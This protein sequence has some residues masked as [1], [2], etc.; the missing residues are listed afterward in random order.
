[1]SRWDGLCDE[2]GDAI[3][4]DRPRSDYCS[5]ACSYRSRDRRRYAENAEVQRERSRRYYLE[6]RAEVLARA[7]ARRGAAR[8][9][10]LPSTC[11]E[12][13]RELE[14]RQRVTCGS[15]RCR[16]RRFAR[17]RPE[18]YAARERAKVERRRERRREQRA[19]GAR[20]VVD[21]RVAEIP[22]PLR[23]LRDRDL[24]A[25]EVEE[26][27]EVRFVFSAELDDR[28]GTHAL[29]GVDDA[30][31]AVDAADLTEEGV[32]RGP[33]NHDL[34]AAGRDGDPI[35]SPHSPESTA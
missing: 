20:K 23:E 17:L 21:E 26:L 34:A 8:E 3:P 13:G 14:G 12:C 29:E 35:E 16:D 4:A 18:S 32:A 15:S 11:A 28:G 30:L 19:S 6:H 24:V 25:P 5:S 31:G 1:M 33:R 27:E 22:D 10:P 7:K 9:T 2:C